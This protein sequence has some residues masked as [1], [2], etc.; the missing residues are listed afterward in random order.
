[1]QLYAFTSVES[2]NGNTFYNYLLNEFL[3]LKWQSSQSIILQG[4][5]KIETLPPYNFLKKHYK[6]NLVLRERTEYVSLSI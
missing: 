2:C 1:M 3:I 5:C 6:E 4:A